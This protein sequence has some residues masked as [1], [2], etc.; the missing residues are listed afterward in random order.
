[1]NDNDI[2]KLLIINDITGYGRVSTFAMLPIMAKYGLHPYILPTSLVSNTMD[3]GDCEI[4]ETTEFIEK[5]LKQWSNFGFKFSSIATG[6]INSAKQADIIYS[7]IEE[8]KPELLIVDPIMADSGVLYPNMNPDS[9]NY[10]KKIISIS[11]I[12][13]PNLTEARLLT[14]SKTTNKYTNDDELLQITN[15]LMKIGC[16]NIVITDCSD[17]EN[18]S[19]NYIYD[20]SS[21]K[22][23][24]IYFEKLPSKFIGT[25]DVFSAMLISETLLGAKLQEAVSTA[26]DFVAKVIKD[27]ADNDDNYDLIIEKSLEYIK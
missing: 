19:F 5:T 25:G 1:M 21:S 26:S 7:F 17:I 18:K 9:I 11:D 8:T 16:K 14:E 23:I 20:Q 24:K 22:S 2:K 13:I 12:C 27:N 15:K 3:Y 6:F 10:Y 4:L